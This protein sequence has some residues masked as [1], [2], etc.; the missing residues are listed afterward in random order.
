[1]WEEHR[2]RV[3]ESWVLR[4]V[5]ELKRDEVTEEWKKNICIMRSLMISTPHQTLFG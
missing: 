4:N 3:F 1:M 2:L 5:F